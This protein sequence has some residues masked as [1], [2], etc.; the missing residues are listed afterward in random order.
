[1]VNGPA[2]I[3]T[4]GAPSSPRLAST[5]ETACPPFEGCG[6]TA[7]RQTTPVTRPIPAH[8]IDRRSR[9]AISIAVA[10]CQEC[11]ITHAGN[12]GSGIHTPYR[13]SQVARRNNSTVSQCIQ[14][15]KQTQRMK[16]LQLRVGHRTELS[17]VEAKIKARELCG[18]VY[19]GSRFCID[20]L[21]RISRSLSSGDVAGCRPPDSR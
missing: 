3:G 7:P 15:T 16:R 12:R 18:E 6:S 8:N 10:F 9:I 5:D 4:I 19:N 2:G 20:P 1:M 17:V 11:C 21:I 13:G 14:L